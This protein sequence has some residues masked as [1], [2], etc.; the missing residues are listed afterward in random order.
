MKRA[1][2]IAASVLLMSLSA[3]AFAQTKPER[4][5][6]PIQEKIQALRMQY[7]KNDSLITAYKAE[8]TKLENQNQQIAGYFQAI[9]DIQTLSAVPSAVDSTK[10][11]K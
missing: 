9:Q 4:N 7:Q 11:K 10:E 5:V 1:I 8:I 6:S 3:S 2:F